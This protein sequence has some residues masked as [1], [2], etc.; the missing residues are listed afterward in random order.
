MSTDVEFTTA[1]L[2]VDLQQATASIPSVLDMAT[3]VANAARL[4]AAF[5]ERGLPVALIT[6]DLNHPPVGRTAYSD[7][8]RPAIPDAALALLPELGPGDDDI[9]LGKRGWSAFAGTDLD[10]MLRDRGV[11]QVVLVGLATSYGIESTARQ[12]YDLGYHVV[13]VGDAINNPQA[14]GHEHSMTRVFP[15]LA[16]VTITDDVLAL[17]PAAP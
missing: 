1:L 3:V 8:V 2:V 9:L 13:I 14:E 7:R 12:G 4:A 15:V 10:G 16:Q 5:R 17:L 6:T 11:T